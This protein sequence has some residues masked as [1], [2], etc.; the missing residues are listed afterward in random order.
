MVRY[1]G[2]MTEIE[3]LEKWEDIV[4]VL[5]DNEFLCVD[6]E[7]YKLKISRFYLKR[8]TKEEIQE[9]QKRLPEFNFMTDCHNDEEKYRLLDYMGVKLE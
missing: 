7:T 8:M 3:D 5:T 1:E 6:A 4:N 2:Y 9:V